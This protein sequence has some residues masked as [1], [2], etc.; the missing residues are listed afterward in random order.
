MPEMLAK[1]QWFGHNHHPRLSKSCCG[2]HFAW[3][4]WIYALG[5]IY[6][7]IYEGICPDM[8]MPQ[9]VAVDSHTASSHIVIH[10][11]RSK[12][13][14]FGVGA[15]LHLGATDQLLCPVAALLGYLAVQPQ[16]VGP[17]LL[18]RDGTT[19]SKPRL[20]SP[21]RQVLQEVGVGLSC[22]SGHSFCIGAA[23]AAAKLG[24]N[25][26]MIKVL[27]RWGIFGIHT[28]YTDALRTAGT[29]VVCGVWW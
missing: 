25:D 28:L 10:L 16:L 3:D 17:L 15:F 8:L 21:L 24:V 27:G 6:L 9:D 20:I 22:Y 11:K 2:Q 1:I 29:D 19:L 4:F 12:N 13:Y 23:T 26:S 7:F 5:R 18:F 14:P